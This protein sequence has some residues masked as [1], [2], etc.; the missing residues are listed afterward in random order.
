[1]L[2]QSD[3]KTAH[4]L[5]GHDIGP[6][7]RVPVAGKVH[8]NVGMFLP[9]PRQE[10]MKG[11]DTLRPGSREQNRY[12]VCGSSLCIADLEAIDWHGRNRSDIWKLC[13][14]HIRA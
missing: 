5:G 13:I 9:K 11:I 1:M 4:G 8:G 6:A 12:P 3:D 7:V 14:A 2:H 10:P